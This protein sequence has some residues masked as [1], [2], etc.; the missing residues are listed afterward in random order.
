MAPSIVISLR[1]TAECNLRRQVTAYAGN[2]A[3]NATHFA[4]ARQQANRLSRDSSVAPPTASGH[5]MIIIWSYNSDS[6]EQAISSRMNRKV[7]T[8]LFQPPCRCS[9]GSGS[10]RMDPRACEARKAC[11]G[12][13]TFHPCI[14]QDL[15]GL[16]FALLAVLSNFLLP[17]VEDHY[18]R[19]P[20]ASAA[21]GGMSRISLTDARAAAMKCLNGTFKWN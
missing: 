14:V 19:T 6:C 18:Q 16:C 13:L 9:A 17:I 20:C 1:V 4:S 10:Q 8:Q 2:K 5:R 3:V 7:A 12:G 15:P 21:F 11:S